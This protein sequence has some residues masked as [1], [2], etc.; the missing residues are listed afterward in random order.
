MEDGF[1]VKNFFQLNPKDQILQTM[2]LT[3]WVQHDF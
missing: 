3:L 2:D 1:F